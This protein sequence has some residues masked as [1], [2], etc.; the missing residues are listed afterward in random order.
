VLALALLLLQLGAV[1]VPSS[2][3][4]PVAP[5]YGPAIKL[6]QATGGSEPRVTVA[7]NGHRYVISN[8]TSGTAK[9]WQSVNDGKSWQS[10]ANTFPNQTSPTIDVDV[11]TT[12]TGRIIATELDFGGINFITGYSDDGGKTWTASTGTQYADQDRQWLAVGPDDPQSHQPRVYMLWHN[13]GSGAA[14]HNTFVA[15]STDGGATFGPPVPTTLPGDDSWID[16]QCADSGGPSNLMVNQQTGQIYAVF[17]TRAAPL[18][19]DVGGCGAS[20]VPGPFE[21]NIVAAT[22]VWI[23]TSTDGSPGSWH[24][25]LAVD[26]AAAN[27]IVGMQLAPGAVDRS[28]N[29]Y[30]LY[31]ESLNAYPDYSGA[32]IKLVHAPADLSKWSAPVTVAPT[33]GAGHL[34]P[35]IIAGEAGKIDYAYFTGVD[36][37]G[38]TPAWYIDAG[39]SLNALDPSPAFASVRLSNVAT[40]SG[41]ASTLM[42]AC[43]TGPTQPANG[44]NCNR[45]TDVWGMA[46]DASCNAVVTWPG[47]NNDA[48]PRN[49]GSGTYVA[50]QT[51]GNSVCGQATASAA[52]TPSAS[53][54]PPLPLTGTESPPRFQPGALIPALIVPLLLAATLRRR[55]AS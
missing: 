7:P 6:D 41:T 16:L 11:V 28:G 42:G 15:T 8:L 50:S 1:T 45:S 32:A 23:A 2:A 20:F 47:V 25:S 36:R 39:Q 48:N 29:V 51:G 43:N 37:A 49:Q 53:P 34:L 46:L 22:R 55:R 3:A 17:G 9:L 38:K 24:S 12:R 54:S 10:V 52:A 44:F 18:G 30:V 27:K 21:I 40:Y 4:A 14:D 31:P 33:G 26:D 35:H 13:L 5:V 19:V